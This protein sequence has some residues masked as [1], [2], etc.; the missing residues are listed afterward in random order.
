MSSD[1]VIRRPHSLLVMDTERGGFIL[2]YYSIPHR[3]WEGRL[4]TANGRFLEAVRGVKVCEIYAYEY[5]DS[6]YESR[7]IEI[8]VMKC[9]TLWIANLNIEFPIPKSAAN[10]YGID[11]EAYY[12]YLD[13]I[14]DKMVD[15]IRNWIGEAQKE[16]AGDIASFISEYFNSEL[17]DYEAYIGGWVTGNPDYQDGVYYGEYCHSCKSPRS[18]RDIQQV[19]GW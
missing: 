15:Y 2:I 14:L 4:I 6:N 19:G 12:Q 5:C 17:L 10:T 18:C 3:A 8:E 11:R 9:K 1:L 13:P 7:N 16:V